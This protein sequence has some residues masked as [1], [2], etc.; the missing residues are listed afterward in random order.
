MTDFFVIAVGKQWFARL[1]SRQ[2]G[3]QTSPRV[4]GAAVLDAAEAQRL[5]PL[6][7]RSR[8]RVRVEVL[9][10]RDPRTRR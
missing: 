2:G 10:E 5:V 1:I 8:H 3:I 4:T 9:S 6:I 7:R